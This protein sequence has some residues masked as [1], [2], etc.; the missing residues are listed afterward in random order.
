MPTGIKVR[1]LFPVPGSLQN[2]MVCVDNDYNTPLCNTKQ[3][4]YLG[5]FPWTGDWE[6]TDGPAQGFVYIGT[7]PYV[8]YET[9]YFF[10][11]KNLIVV[12]EPA[13]FAVY[14][15]DSSDNQ[16]YACTNASPDNPCIFDVATMYPNIASSN[17][18]IVTVS[19]PSI[20]WNTS[21]YSG[22]LYGPTSNITFSSNYSDLLQQ[23]ANNARPWDGYV[24]LCNKTFI[25]TTPNGGTIQNCSVSGNTA[26]C[27][28][29]FPNFIPTDAC[30]PGQYQ[31]DMIVTITSIVT[32]NSHLGYLVIR[33][34]IP[35]TFIF[36]LPPTTSLT[37]TPTCPA[38]GYYGVISAQPVTSVWTVG[39]PL[40]IVL[41]M[42][43]PSPPSQNIPIDVIATAFICH[44]FSFGDLGYLAYYPANQSQARITMTIPPLLVPSMCPPGSY[45]G[46]LLLDLSV[47]DPRGVSGLTVEVPLTF[48]FPST[49]TTTSVPTTTTTIVTSTWTT[50]YQ[51]VPIITVT[52]S[53]TTTLTQ[54]T[55]VMPTQTMT[56]TTTKTTMPAPTTPP[57]AAAPTP[58]PVT[59][60]PPPKAGIYIAIGAVAII[61][62]AGLGYYLYSRRKR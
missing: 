21:N 48:V 7:L 23:I 3:S 17:Q 57:L 41:E 28:M 2:L 31:G 6:Q 4:S 9:P 10:P 12:V 36:P 49:T 39:Q 51:T 13:P 32:Y 27:L 5:L 50:T 14:F 16:L 34:V 40:Q 59:P 20:T 25:F 18:G 45:N 61:A 24:S 30:P 62:L 29:I 53:P 15:Y 35:A 19:I 55:T 42:C 46:K 54:T 26:T 52:T 47:E 37:T 43:S 44:E 22:S 8:Y 56:Q 38:V 1:V 60:A 33:S 11:T 58:T